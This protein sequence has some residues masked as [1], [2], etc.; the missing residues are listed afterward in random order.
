MGRVSKRNGSKA[1]QVR[2][3]RVVL[4]RNRG[5]LLGWVKAASLEAAEI[6]AAQTFNLTDWQRKRLL[7]R[8]HA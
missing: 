1:I 7:L 5:H 4:I 2:E 3:W 6:A 8:P